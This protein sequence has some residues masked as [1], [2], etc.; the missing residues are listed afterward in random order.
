MGQAF[1]TSCY[2]VEKTW[3]STCIKTRTFENIF[4]IWFGMDSLLCLSQGRTRSS[5]KEFEFAFL[6]M[7]SSAQK[8]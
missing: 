7:F 3:R 5:W 1:Q 2:Y 4:K 6:E 8:D